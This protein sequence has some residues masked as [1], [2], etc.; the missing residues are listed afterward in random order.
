MNDDYYYL[1]SEYICKTIMIK[2]NTNLQCVLTTID[3]GSR[4]ETHRFPRMTHYATIN[5][6]V[7]TI[8]ITLFILPILGLRNVG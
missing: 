3:N 7:K 5:P 4:P 8:Y 1:L 2:F 6:S